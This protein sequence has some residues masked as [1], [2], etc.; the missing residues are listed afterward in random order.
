MSRPAPTPLMKHSRPDLAELTLDSACSL[1]WLRSR[2]LGPALGWPPPLHLVT[3]PPLQSKEQFKYKSVLDT[4]RASASLRAITG[5]EGPGFLSA[6]A[7]KLR[8]AL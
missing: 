8:L 1:P 2:E 4:N 6:S 5:T 7:N 3:G